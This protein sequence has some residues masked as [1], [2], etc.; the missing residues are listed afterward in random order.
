MDQL[1]KGEPFAEL[2]KNRSNG[3]RRENGGLWDF[4]R[5]GV[6]PKP[7]DQLLFSLPV[8]E[9]GGPVETEI[10]YT[11]VK[12]EA[13]KPGRTIPFEEVQP[14]IEALLKARRQDVRY[15]ELMRRLEEEN[16]VERRE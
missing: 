11:I 4:V 2:A 10:G 13:H 14:K 8:G 5:Q 15:L 7:V 16:Y 9:V 12:V 3:P 6:R 1:R